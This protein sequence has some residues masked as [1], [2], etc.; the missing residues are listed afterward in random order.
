MPEVQAQD[1]VLIEPL[2]A[3]EEADARSQNGYFLPKETFSAKQYR[4]VKVNMELLETDGELV[5]PLF[6]GEKLVARS[7]E[8]EVNRES[9]YLVWH[10]ERDKDANQPSWEVFE[11]AVADQGLSSEAAKLMFNSYVEQRQIRINVNYHEQDEETG[12]NLNP[13]TG[14]F[15]ALS[16]CTV[17]RFARYSS[18]PNYVR[19]VSAALESLDT[20]KSYRLE[21]LGMGGPYHV[22]YEIDPSR[23]TIPGNDVIVPGEPYHSGLTP[24]QDQRNM[25]LIQ[26]RND[27]EQRIGPN[28]HD[29]LYEV[30]IQAVRAS[31]ARRFQEAQQQ[32]ITPVIHGC[33]AN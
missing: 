11:K 24:E 31:D 12:A 19:G 2:S 20:K 17:D 9:G 32:Q 21:M 16:P 5:I 27:L 14:L 25:L 10:G 13:V 4:L 1:R 23:M 30:R 26:E 28:P 33:E 15:D 29:A 22:L 18:D 6:D 3:V 8:I 7:I